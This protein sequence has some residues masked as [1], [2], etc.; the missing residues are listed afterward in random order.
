MQNS[1]IEGQ[2]HLNGQARARHESQKVVPKAERPRT[3]WRLA[4]KSK[5]YRGIGDLMGVFS[6]D[7]GAK[8]EHN[9]GGR[10]VFVALIVI[11]RIRIG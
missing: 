7:V 10:G 6:L 1:D 11:F 3:I 8:V 4:E 2:R 9:N 5:Q